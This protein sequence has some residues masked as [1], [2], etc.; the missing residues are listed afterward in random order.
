MITKLDES[1]IGRWVWYIPNHAK[2]DKSQWE[3]GRIKSFSNENQRAWVV[4]KAN[5]NLGLSIEVW[6]QF[7]GQA[8]S[9]D[10]LEFIK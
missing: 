10:D 3:R 9:Y 8:T 7:T 6:G 5:G 1:S 4:Y 2:D